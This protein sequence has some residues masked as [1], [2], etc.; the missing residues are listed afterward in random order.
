MRL[1]DDIFPTKYEYDLYRGSPRVKLFM[2]ETKPLT[3]EVVVACLL[4]QIDRGNT[5]IAR[6]KREGVIKG[7]A[8]A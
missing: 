8:L 1:P 7:S 5:E 2:A 3:K 4:K 6:L